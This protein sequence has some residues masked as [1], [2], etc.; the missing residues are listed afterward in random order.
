MA[1]ID[2]LYSEDA[3]RQFDLI[4]QKTKEQ[5]EDTKKLIEISKLLNVELSKQKATKENL[6]AANTETNRLN[7]QLESTKQK[8]AGLSTEEAKLLEIEK[9]KLAA[10]NKELK[11]TAALENQELGTREKLKLKNKELRAE[12]DKLDLTR[13]KGRQ[14]LKEIN[15]QLEKNE[16][17]LTNT[18]DAYVKTKRNVGNYTQGVKEGINQS[19]LFTSQMYLLQRGQAAAAAGTQILKS[20]FGSLR[21][22]II[23]T[24]IGALVIGI[25]A[26]VSAFTSTEEGATKLQKILVPFKILFGN[27]KDVLI[28]I[29]DAI[30]N[31]FVNPIETIKGFG[32]FIKNIFSPIIS[33]LGKVFSGLGD[34]ITG[35]F[36]SDKRQAGI[37][38]LKEGAE[39]IG[40]AIKKTYDDGKEAV[41]GFRKKQRE[42]WEENKK[43]TQ[44]AIDLETAKLK[45]VQAERKAKIDL[46]K[47]DAE[48]SELRVKA[49]DEE[50][51][52]DAERLEFLDLA[53]A[54][55]NEKMKINETLAKQ[56][57][58]QI[59]LE[60]T[61][62]TTNAEG[63]DAA[64][65]AEAAL[66]NVRTQNAN[67]SRRLESQRQTILKQIATDSK[68]N[69]TEEVK[70]IE[71]VKKANED[72]IKQI[73][74]LTVD[75]L[76]TEIERNKFKRELELQAIEQSLADEEYKAQQRA[77]ITQKY[78]TII[79]DIEK[80]EKQVRL[81]DTKD[82]LD[83]A[84]GLF[85]QNTLAY[86]G[87][88]L[89]KIAIDT[90]QAISGLT[91]NSETNPANAVTFGGAGI[92]QFAAGIIRILTNLGSAKKLITGAKFADGG[93]VG[94]TGLIQ[95]GERGREL[96]VTPGG[97]VGLSPD[98]TSFA[99]AE[100][101]TKIYKNTETERILKGI[102]PAKDSRVVNAIESG[103]MKIVKAIKQSNRPRLQRDNRSIDKRGGVYKEYLNSK[104][105]N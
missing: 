92:L 9:Q 3:L 83:Q 8:L 13:Q 17:A 60:N 12:L 42:F 84:Q 33:G 72:A 58:E 69:A 19:G 101:G 34:I 105:I 66:I 63:L 56:K 46:A 70:N 40:T 49:L 90:G 68:T 85:K 27:L 48:I 22:A 65:E 7:K 81:A 25:L 5:I 29:G 18:S 91:A 16:K 20:G 41:E 79:T 47:L 95:W 36:D 45:L 37:D 87:I 39:D 55:E 76:T 52:S 77:L 54:K 4:T 50:N 21:A 2:S 11:I 57:L 28:D 51:L 80:A 82:V 59:N 89:A 61:F 1:K 10:R 98:S 103:N 26:L 38:K 74:D 67:A 31:A 44:Q 15:T 78:E 23:S 64:A 102:Q 96:F 6:N 97:D 53:I 93:I 73:Q 43:E 100:R 104:I 94:D 62:S 75:A 35:I 30:I 24:G 32:T 71:L 86:K 88:A 14:R 99:F